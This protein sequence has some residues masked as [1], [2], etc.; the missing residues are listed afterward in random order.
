M[1]VQFLASCILLPSTS[2]EL[3]PLPCIF[4]LVLSILFLFFRFIELAL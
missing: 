2:E 4:E 3:L 1:M